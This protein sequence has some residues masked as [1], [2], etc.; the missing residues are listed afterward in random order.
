MQCGKQFVLQ[1]ICNS[2]KVVGKSVY[3]TILLKTS[4]RV[5]VIQPNGEI[6]KFK[7][8]SERKE[9]KKAGIREYPQFCSITFYENS[10]FIFSASQLF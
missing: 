1:A 4:S 5:T 3:Y 9:E 6:L 10:K 8:I 2:A 7:L